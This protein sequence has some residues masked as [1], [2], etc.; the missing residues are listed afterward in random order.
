[1]KV[2][3]EFFSRCSFTFRSRTNTRF[4]EDTWL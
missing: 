4:W 2:K 1:M 3:K